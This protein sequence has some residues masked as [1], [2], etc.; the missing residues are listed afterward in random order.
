M[1]L[2]IVWMPQAQEG[3]MDA[4]ARWT[5]GRGAFVGLLLMLSWLVPA[6]AQTV[7][8]CVDA[9]GRITL[10]SAACGPGQR[11]DASYDASPELVPVAAEVRATPGSESRPGRANVSRAVAGRS[12][13]TS[14]RSRSRATIDRCEAARARRE[15]TLQRVGLKR[16]F[17]L[18]R[19]LDDEVWAACR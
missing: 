3:R 6:A 14:T 12:G 1:R 15:R 11:L 8:K 16:T 9:D 2:G 4:R 10:T 7:Q 5:P 17:D 18:L 19:K 13:R